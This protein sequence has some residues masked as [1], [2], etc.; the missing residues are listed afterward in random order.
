MRIPLNFTNITFFVSG[1]RA[2]VPRQGESPQLQ[3]EGQARS[4][5][6]PRLPGLR[7]QEVPQE[8]GDPL[9]G[10]DREEVRVQERQTGNHF[11]RFQRFDLC[12]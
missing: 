8:Q 6:R 4:S 5:L 1:R 2:D 12:D 11:L 7:G 3:R 10:A 9:R